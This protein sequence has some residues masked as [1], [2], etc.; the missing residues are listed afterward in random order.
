MSE[1]REVTV[2]H[3]ATDRHTYVVTYICEQRLGKARCRCNDDEGTLRE[4]CPYDAGSASHVCADHL[5]KFSVGP[6]QVEIRC[7]ICKWIEAKF[8]QP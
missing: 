8:P 3:R 5:R 4:P 7:F 2:L 6:Q 1:E